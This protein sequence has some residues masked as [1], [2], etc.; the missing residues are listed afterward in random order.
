MRIYIDLFNMKIKIKK[1]LTN[2]FIRYCNN[3]IT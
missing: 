2:T 1:K 3:N